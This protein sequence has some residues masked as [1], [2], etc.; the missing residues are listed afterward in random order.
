LLLAFQAVAKPS[1]GLAQADG[2]V[3]D[4]LEPLRIDVGH[5]IAVR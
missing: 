5:S 4:G 3:H 2:E 1:N